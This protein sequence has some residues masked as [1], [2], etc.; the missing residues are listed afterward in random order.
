MFQ[1]ENAFP[2]RYIVKP[3]LV[4]AR[5]FRSGKQTPKETD[6]EECGVREI[7]DG[8]FNIEDVLEGK[9][10]KRSK[11]KNVNTTFENANFN[12]FRP[13]SNKKK[14]K[15]KL[16]MSVSKSNNNVTKENK[17][18]SNINRSQQDIT[19]EMDGDFNEDEY[20]K[21]VEFYEK[22]LREG[23]DENNSNYAENNINFRNNY[24]SNAENTERKNNIERNN[25]ETGLVLFKIFSTK[26][27]LK[28]I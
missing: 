8:T 26:I 14:L 9:T 10:R 21:Q 6:N 5:V 1:Q 22:I 13:N 23:N 19:N 17:N 7:Y 3:N 18:A 11:G 24:N 25:N 15:D 4:K 16:N 27:I 20:K 12:P 2:E 28:Y